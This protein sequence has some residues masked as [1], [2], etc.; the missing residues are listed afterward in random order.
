MYV[1]VEKNFAHTEMKYKL[2]ITRLKLIQCK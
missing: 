1:H 2:T